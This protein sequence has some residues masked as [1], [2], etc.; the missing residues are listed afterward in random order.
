VIFQSLF[1]SVVGFL[2]ATGA[3][4]LFIQSLKMEVMG[5][6]LEPAIDAGVIAGAFV[7]TMIIGLLSVAYPASLAARLSIAETMRGE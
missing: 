6:T 4:L 7:L 5:M 3:A 2:V 1:V